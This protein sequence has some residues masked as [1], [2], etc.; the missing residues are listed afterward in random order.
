[1]KMTLDEA[2][3]VLDAVKSVYYEKGEDGS[4]KERVIPFGL[5]Y[6]LI[7]IKDAF[8]KDT[9]LFATEREALIRKYGEEVEQEG[10][11]VLKVKDDELQNF[12]KEINDILL[13]EVEIDYPKLTLQDVEKLEEKEIELSE[14]HLKMLGKYVFE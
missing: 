1:M 3:V 8:E 9:A 4:Q 6:R 7:K 12:L 11:Q 5:K 13:T 14:I 2:L 10:Q